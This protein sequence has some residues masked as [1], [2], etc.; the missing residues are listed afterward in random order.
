MLCEGSIFE[1][2]TVLE[3][4][5]WRDGGEEVP[6]PGPVL[7][8]ISPQGNWVSQ[9]GAGINNTQFSQACLWSLSAASFLRDVVV[10]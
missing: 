1:I 2:R 9:W 5:A 3:S 7:L 6:S 4:P 10:Q 8:Q